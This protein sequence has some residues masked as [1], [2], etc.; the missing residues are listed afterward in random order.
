MFIEK[1]CEVNLTGHKRLGNSLK[2]ARKRGGSCDKQ[3][4]IILFDKL[5]Q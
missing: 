2:L 4:T 5:R 1:L 3:L